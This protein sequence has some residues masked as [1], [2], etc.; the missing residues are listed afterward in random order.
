MGRNSRTVILRTGS[1]SATV[2]AFTLVELL[3]VIGIIAVL[4]GILLPVLS[5]ARESANTL[6]CATH[7]R[8]IGMA[9]SVY[10][11][12]NKGKLPIP[13]GGGA[14]GNLSYSAILLRSDN[15]YFGQLDFSQGTLVPYLHG[16][17]VAQRLFTCPS[18]T[19]PRYSA[20]QPVTPDREAPL[21][22]QPA[23]TRNFSYAFSGTLAGD[24]I[25]AH[26]TG[27][28]TSQIRRPSEKLLIQETYMPPYAAHIAVF[29]NV[30]GVP[31]AI[32]LNRRHG[33]KSNQYFADGHVQLFDPEILRDENVSNPV[34]APLYLHYV[35]LRAP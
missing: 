1:D 2:T 34:L 10:A 9:C 17:A 13:I 5:K 29:Y 23:V 30:N 18:D 15:N 3:V 27:T 4:I 33:G 28:K 24:V 12:D 22:P 8:E 16:A 11:A 26:Y 7:L 6:V 21:T 31:C 25:G 14:A 19:E 20:F 32:F 35:S